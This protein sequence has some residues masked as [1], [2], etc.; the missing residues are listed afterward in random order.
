MR[1]LLLS[2]FLAFSLFGATFTDSM[3]REVEIEKSQKIV[4]IGPGSLRLL[5]YMGLQEKIIGVEKRELDFDTKAPYRAALNKEQISKLPIIGQG[6]PNAMPNLESLI[7]LKPDIIFSSFLSREQ[8]DA[9]TQKTSIPVVALS[10]GAT[11]GGK[12]EKLEAIKNS[13]KL[14]GKITDSNKKS[15]ELITFME[16]EEQALAK[17][18]LESKK[19]YIAGIGYKGAQGITSTES[20]YPP[21][22]LLGLQN[23]VM[24]DKKG[25]A[26]IQEESILAT[27]PDVIFLDSLGKK[28]IEEELLKK[29]SFYSKLHAFEKKELYWLYP[30]NFYNT[31]VENIYI[32]S[33]IIAAHLGAKVDI[34]S[35]KSEILELFLGREAAKNLSAQKLP[36]F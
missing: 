25:H 30:Y 21:F 7:T 1:H 15:E 12:E 32:N 35:K 22:A 23:S 13:L 33:W 28:I 11:Y 5:V 2:L 26:F 31:N 36:K 17:I 4:A 19:L 24:G 29:E 27:N 6:G 14:I 3:G 10:Y 9:L 34:E 20:D 18:D 16:K 8:I